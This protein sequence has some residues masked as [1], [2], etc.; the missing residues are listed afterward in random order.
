MAQENVGADAVLGAVAGVAGGA[1]GAAVNA[2]HSASAALDGL[3]SGPSSQSFHVNE[4][5]VLKAGVIIQ[6]QAAVLARA[7]RK[8]ESHLDVDVN[9]S[10]SGIVS[11]NIAG[12]WNR[13][14]TMG[15]D[16]Y[17]GRIRLY[18]ESL[19]KLSGQLRESAKQ[20]GFSEE[21]IT[22]TFGPVT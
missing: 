5:N 22:T 18:V 7:L 17:V 9:S 21:E 10:D 6:D 3:T 14:L 16:S 15:D 12:A 11:S 19:D 8:A 13:R 2:L 4:G 1:I 20:Y